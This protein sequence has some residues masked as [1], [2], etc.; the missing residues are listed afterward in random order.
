MDQFVSIFFVENLE[1]K[2]YFMLDFISLLFGHCDIAGERFCY[3]VW[4]FDGLFGFFW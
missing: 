2:Q 3:F 4:P 1:S